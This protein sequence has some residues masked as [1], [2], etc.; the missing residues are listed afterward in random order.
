[1]FFVFCF[2]FVFWLKF[3][4]FYYIDY[5]IYAISKKLS[6]IQPKLNQPFIIQYT[7]KHE[8]QIECGGGFI[9]LFDTF[10]VQEN[11]NENTP[12]V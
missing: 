11:L 3:L 1:M 9:K 12:Y 4:L 10:F 2:L 8:Q 5:R 7:I 6:T